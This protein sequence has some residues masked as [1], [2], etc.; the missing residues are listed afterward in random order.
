MCKFNVHQN[1]TADGV[2]ITSG[3]VVWTNDMNVGRVVSDN[4]QGETKCC[5]E[6]THKGQMNLDDHSWFTDHDAATCDDSTKFC[7]HDHWFRVECPN[8]GGGSF[9]GERLATAHRTY[10]GRRLLAL[11]AL[12]DVLTPAPVEW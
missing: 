5:E 7:R 10:D 12:G 8:G 4:C 2:V 1:R 9:N 11:D 3:L 6:P